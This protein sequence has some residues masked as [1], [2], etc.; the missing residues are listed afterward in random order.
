MALMLELF[1]EL[2]E[3]VGEAVHGPLEA[4]QQIE[5]H[6]DGEADAGDCGEEVLF[7]GDHLITLLVGRVMAEGMAAK[8]QPM[9]GG[10]THRPTGLSPSLGEFLDFDGADVRALVGDGEGATYEEGFLGDD[11][12][13]PGFDGGIRDVILRVEQG[14]GLRLGVVEQEFDFKRAFHGETPFVV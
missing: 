13:G 3:L 10:M 9:R 12:I 4:G 6:D 1:D 8:R 7:H 14:D 2:A 5:R 11:I